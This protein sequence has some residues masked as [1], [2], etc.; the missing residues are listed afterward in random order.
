MQWPTQQEWARLHLLRHYR[1]PRI[2]GWFQRDISFAAG[3]APLYRILDAKITGYFIVVDCEPA[4][5][6]DLREPVVFPDHSLSFALQYNVWA[7]GCW[8]EDTP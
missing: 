8:K 2:V 1:Q 6:D 3:P 7:P 4:V 5:R